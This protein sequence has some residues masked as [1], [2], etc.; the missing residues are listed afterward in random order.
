MPQQP[1]Q[2]SLK[3]LQ[4]LVGN[5]I[6]AYETEP[7]VTH[8]RR[9]KFAGT[10]LLAI[11]Q[12]HFRSSLSDALGANFPAILALIGEDYFQHVTRRFVEASPPPGAILAE[13]GCGFADH[14]AEN[15]ALNPFPY[16]ADVARLEW[17]WNEAFHEADAASLSAEELT[18]LAT[19]ATEEAPLDLFLHPTVRLIRSPYPLA[20]IWEMARFGA[21]DPD[22]IDLAPADYHYLIIRSGQMP[23]V[24]ALDAGSFAF[25]E[26]LAKS[27]DFEAAAVA[28][29]AAAP[30]FSLEGS[31]G[32]L[33]LKGVFRHP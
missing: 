6:E 21:L 5:A 14:L 17:H 32:S 9:G 28:A 25:L 16:L 20:K 4:H 10:D 8:I 22:D 24:F 23:E 15:D 26:A 33:L 27:P 13:Y 29:M 1:D 3:S 30:D 11:H 19:N 18:A 2:Q 7:A 12:N 31:L